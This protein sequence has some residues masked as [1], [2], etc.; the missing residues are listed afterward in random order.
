[1]TFLQVRV[2]ELDCYCS[3]LELRRT[4]PLEISSVFCVSFSYADLQA[5]RFGKL[6]EL[7]AV[8]GIESG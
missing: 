5:V 8:K 4:D 2:R 7:I 1:M 6:V 3:D